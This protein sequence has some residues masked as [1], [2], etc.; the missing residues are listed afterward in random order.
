MQTV[1]RRC[2]TDRYRQPA[3]E[4]RVGDLVL[5]LESHEATKAGKPVHLTPLEFRILY[6]L[7]MNE[8]RVIPHERLVDYAWGYE[9]GRSS[10]LKAHISHL[11]NKVSLAPG[12]NGGIRSVSGVGYS[13]MRA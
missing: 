4:L 2:R 12:R 8:G 11:R 9:G 7:A 3:G 6:I 10:L 1:L 13:L 5:D